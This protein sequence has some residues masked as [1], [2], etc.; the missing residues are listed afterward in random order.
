[1]LF[2][3]INKELKKNKKSCIYKLNVLDYNWGGYNYEKNYV[4]E[5]LFLLKFIFQANSLLLKSNTFK[6]QFLV[7]D[8]NNLLPSIFFFKIQLFRKIW[9][10]VMH[11]T[12]NQTVKT[13]YD[14]KYFEQSFKYWV[15][16][17]KNVEKLS[18]VWSKN[19]FIG[20]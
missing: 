18:K 13:I 9:L 7:S 14:I 12:I 8:L 6:I 11:F 3:S 17:N 4:S 16:R 19:F 20:N 5:N 1:M 2:K 15:I 10:F